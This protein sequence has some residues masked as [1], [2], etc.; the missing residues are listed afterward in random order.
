MA[1][2]TG[3]FAVG[4]GEIFMGRGIVGVL[5][6]RALKKWNRVFRV[7]R[8]SIRANP[9]LAIAS[10]LFGLS[11]NDLAKKSNSVGSAVR[12]LQRLKPVENLASVDAGASLMARWNSAMAFSSSLIS[13]IRLSQFSG[14]Q[15]LPGAN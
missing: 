15:R 3:S 6:Q 10:A 5:R 11:C 9:R 12:A 8:I 2:S 4:G 13:R 7:F 1:S 14:Q